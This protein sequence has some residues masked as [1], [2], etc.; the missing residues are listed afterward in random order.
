MLISLHYSLKYLRLAFLLVCIISI[1]GPKGKSYRQPNNGIGRLTCDFPAA[2][3]IFCATSLSI[4]NFLA[5]C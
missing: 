2:C 5:I 4:P 1:C 3:P